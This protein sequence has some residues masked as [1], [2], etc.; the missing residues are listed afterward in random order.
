[1]SP[2]DEMIFG[3]LQ[4]R[5]P[6]R[7][8]RPDRDPERAWI[9]CG[10]PAP[11]D[12]PIFVDDQTADAIER[13]AYSDRSVELG[14]ILL[15][16]ECVDPETGQPFVWITR[17]LEAQHYEN[18]SASFTYTHEAWEQITRERERRFPDLDIVGWYHTHPDF[19]IFLSGHDEFLHRHFFSQPLQVAYVVDPVRHARGF[20]RWRDG[21]LDPVGGFYLIGARAERVALARLANQLEGLPTA[22]GSVGLAPRLEAELIAMIK[23]PQTPSG[24]ERSSGYGPLVA[25]LSL[26]L[27]AVLT[28][29]AVWLQVAGSELREQSRS[30]RR[31]AEAIPSAGASPPA[32]L[33]V[34]AKRRVLEALLGELRIGEPPEAVATRLQRVFETIDAERRRDSRLAIE[35]EALAR[36]AEDRQ[37]ELVRLSGE[38]ERLRQRAEQLEAEARA[39]DRARASLQPG[40]Q[41]A[42]SASANSFWLAWAA[43]AGWAAFF[44]AVVLLVQRW[45]ADRREPNEPSLATQT[46]PD[47]LDPASSQM[48]R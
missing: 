32:L 26:L 21:R 10:N 2:A 8:P 20:F 27:G 45:L 46:S 4:F 39:T 24:M 41:T 40:P 44:G 36:L 11:D 37:R 13:H 19:G 3:D 5:Q 38:V 28:A 48:N 18:S 16:K 30:L 29:L 14:G 33:E 22:E 31:L 6:A 25:I 12:L 35:N 15:G 42:M 47:R 34:E 17:S 7:L 23:R 43:I 9:V 1:M